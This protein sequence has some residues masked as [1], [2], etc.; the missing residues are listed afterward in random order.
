[1]TA[2]R[3]DHTEDQDLLAHLLRNLANE[4]NL[5]ED[6]NIAGLLQES[7]NNCPP[8]GNSDIVSALLS[9]GPHHGLQRLK[10]QQ[11]CTIPASSEMPQKGLHDVDHHHARVEEIQNPK[12]QRPPGFPFNV[13]DSP[14][15]CTERARDSSARTTKLNNFDLNDIYIDSDDSIEDPPVPATVSLDCQQDSLQSSPPQ[16]SGNSDS[17][18]SQSPSSSSGDTQVYYLYLIR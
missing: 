12:C 7:L 10:R 8:I 14:P 16:T 17:A 11:H 3:T 5:H 2:N 18:S 9:N 6:T 13:Q 15:T 1:M 4:G